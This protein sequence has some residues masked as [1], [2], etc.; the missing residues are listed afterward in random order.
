MEDFPTYKQVEDKERQTL[1]KG[2]ITILQNI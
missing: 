1:R 2:M